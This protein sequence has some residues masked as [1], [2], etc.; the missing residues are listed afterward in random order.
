MLPLQSNFI[1]DKTKKTK[2]EVMKKYYTAKYDRV[3][4]TIFC[5]EDDTYLMREFLTRILE[6]KVEEVQFL[7]N[8]IGIENVEEQVK[9]VDVFALVD[10]VYLHIEMNTGRGEI[11]HAR[12]FT[13][14][15]S[16][17][18]KKTVRG[19]KIDLKSEFIHIDFTYGLGGGRKVKEE[20][21]VMTK[22]GKEYVKNIKMI[23]YI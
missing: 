16:L 20:Y 15:T 10:G 14:F 18:N 2:E 7:R 4:K 13:Y 9:T 8:E 21:K 11:I 12:N 5:N 22:E 23:E 17:Y 19:E 3:F 6:R 1:F